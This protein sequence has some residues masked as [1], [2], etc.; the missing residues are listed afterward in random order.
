MTSP[1]AVSTDGQG[2]KIELTPSRPR[3][4]TE[5]RDSSHFEELSRFPSG[6]HRKRMPEN[7]ADTMKQR[8][9]PSKIQSSVSKS[10][11]IKRLKLYNR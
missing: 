2:T 8:I 5:V 10:R 6:D 9:W 7:K 11:K 4:A 3:E 1:S